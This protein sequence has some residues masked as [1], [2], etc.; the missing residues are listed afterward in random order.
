VKE[1]VN[2]GGLEIWI[3]L[4]NISGYSL[5]SNSAK[6]RNRLLINGHLQSF[7]LVQDLTQQLD[8]MRMCDKNC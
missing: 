1:R 6:S 4:L 7:G 2:F 8:S 5:K 3:S